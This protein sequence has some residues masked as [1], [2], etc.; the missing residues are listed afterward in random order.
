VAPTSRIAP[1]FFRFPQ[2]G[3][4]RL[5]ID[6]DVHSRRREAGIGAKEVAALQ[7]SVRAVTLSGYPEVASHVG[8]DPYDMLRRARIAP[9]V[10]A[11]AENRIPAQIVCKLLEDSARESGCATFGLAMAQCRTFASL[12]PLS[13]LLEHLG[14]AGEVIEALTEYRRHLNDV[15]I[16]G[17]E[18]ADG[19][20]IVR[21]ELLAKFATPQ[22]AD[23]A[24][25][26]AY[27]AL[28]GASRFRWQPLEVHL[29]RTA[30]DDRAPYE[31]L[32]AVPVQFGSTFNGF[33]C[34]CGSMQHHWPWANETMAH[35]VRRLLALV[36]LAPETAPASQSVTRVISLSLPAG[37]ATLPHVAAQLGKSPRTLQRSLSQEGRQFGGLL[38]EVR[39]S[40][41]VHHLSAG[42]SSMT[43]I[44]AML[45][46][47]TSSSFSRWFVMEFG[48]PPR[49]WRAEETRAAAA[50]V[51]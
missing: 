16:L 33:T 47:F 42:R 26:V 34:S 15:V 6:A 38:N 7:P 39:R 44:A 19:E 31:R 1:S 10:L 49:I 4:V 43:S 27:V 40:L 11:E 37:R 17:V 3:S 9:E 45:G 14:S 2:S 20:E 21:V 35:N 51:V 5:R 50:N 41:V 12:G 36:Q 24:I 46:F 13:V 48:V 25:G 29:S 18:K 22:T 23:L 28:S 8:L 32:F 30:P